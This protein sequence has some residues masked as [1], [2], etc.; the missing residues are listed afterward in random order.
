V[1][2]AATVGVALNTLGLGPE[3]RGRALAE[4]TSATGLPASDV[5]AGGAGPLVDALLSARAATGAGGGTR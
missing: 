1:R 3:A 4:V 2:P 5:L